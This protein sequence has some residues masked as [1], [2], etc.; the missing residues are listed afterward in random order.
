[1]NVSIFFTIPYMNNTHYKVTRLK[2]HAQTHTYISEYGT[3]LLF[4][5][6]TD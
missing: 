1:M 2:T 6:H 4:T 5:A 3:T